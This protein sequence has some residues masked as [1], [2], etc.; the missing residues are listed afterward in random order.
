MFDINNTGNSTVCEMKGKNV[1]HIN[2]WVGPHCNTH[3]CKV[4]AHHQIQTNTE[5]LTIMVFLMSI[6]QMQDSIWIRSWLLPFKSF[7]FIIHIPPYQT[8]CKHKWEVCLYLN[9]WNNSNKAIK[10][11]YRTYCKVSI[12]AE[13]KHR[14]SNG[15]TAQSNDESRTVWKT[16]KS[17]SR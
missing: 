13:A 16:V 11:N 9:S 2:K 5:F 7:Q 12:T 10:I 17:G 1:N 3:S 8:S 14:H 4:E 6:K 15:Q